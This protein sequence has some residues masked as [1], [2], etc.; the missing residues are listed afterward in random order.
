[1][2][3]II[4]A[5]GTQFDLLNPT[6]SA[7]HPRDIAASLARICRFNGHCRDHYS[8]AEHSLRVAELVAPEHKLVALLHDATEAYVGDMVSPLKQMLPAYQQIEQRIWHIICE[9]FGISPTLPAEVHQ[10]DL[11]MLAT[12]RRDLMPAHPEEWACLAGV[13]PISGV[14]KPLT[15]TH[16]R[17]YYEKALLSALGGAAQ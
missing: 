14:I 2:T 4:T 5:G 6:A 16:A 9:R 15:A 17:F 1:M 10:A 12:E 7:V 13:T 3:W 8:V 11:T